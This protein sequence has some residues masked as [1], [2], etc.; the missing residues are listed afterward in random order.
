M[1]TAQRKPNKDDVTT[2]VQYLQDHARGRQCAK[3]RRA[4]EKAIAPEAP[5]GFA[6]RMIR[7]IA[8]EANEQGIPVVS[9]DAGY[10]M[11]ES[12][13]DFEPMLAR[14][15]HQRDAMHDRV[16]AVERLRARIFPTRQ[17]A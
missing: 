14:L 15:R 8:H 9:C 3:T 5:A 7:A 2:L 4:I 10:F 11:A 17:S 6:E 13:E 16:L 12:F 1:G